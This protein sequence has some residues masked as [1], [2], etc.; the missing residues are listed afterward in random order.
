MLPIFPLTGVLLLPRA[1]LPLNIF[2][3]RYLAMTEDALATSGRLIGMIQPTEPEQPGKPPPLY[4]VGCAGRITA[5]SETDDGRYLIT[6][7]G[8][9]RFS[10]V[11]ELP[12]V[13]GYR[14]V[15]PDFAR[16]ENDLAADDGDPAID[17]QRLLGA[18]RRYFAIH[19]I[20]ADWE[21]IEQTPDGRL[22]TTLAMAC[23]FSPQE[24]QALLESETPAARAAALI[25]ILE[26]AVLDRPDGE[27]A[28]H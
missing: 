21:A 3:P 20:T 1:R 10:I 12:T 15:M 23:P 17:R 7:V 11:E 26:M 4:S 16:W 6:L 22:M 25:A 13:R 8:V 2:E 19:G 27:S 9:C 14:R 18:L 24:K 28:K 5:F